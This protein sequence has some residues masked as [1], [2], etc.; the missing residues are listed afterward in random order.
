MMALLLKPRFR[1]LVTI[2]P[3]GEGGVQQVK[4]RWCVASALQLSL[5]PG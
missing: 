3:Y 5:I 2:Q 4:S 1:K